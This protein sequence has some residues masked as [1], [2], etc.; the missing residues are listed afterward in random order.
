MYSQSVIEELRVK[1]NLPVNASILN[2]FR[3]P[4]RTTPKYRETDD[5]ATI[6]LLNDRGWFIKTYKQVKPHTKYAD[7]GIYKPFVAMYEN[8]NLPAMEGEGNITLVHRNAKDGTKLNELFAG[9]YRYVCENGLILGNALF[10]P[11]R[12][13]HIG[14]M[15][16]QLDT[17]VVKICDA[18]PLVY[19]A[20]TDMQSVVLT[21]DQQFE[22]ATK[23]IETRF[24]GEKYV[25]DPA[26]VL[27]P[28]RK[29]DEG[30][31]L[32]RVFNRCQENLIKASGLQMK[33]KDNKVRKVK[34]ITNIDVNL[35][36]NRA[37]WN[38]SQSY[39]V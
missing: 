5:I 30:N 33:N 23:A 12:V 37:L 28:N 17:V 25:V 24:D 4:D 3:D 26:L 29:E 6:Q 14:D 9:F 36:V 7:K 16:Q 39:L 19:K 35:K 2:N 18:C 32:W 10:E 34:A 21:R 20:I 15:P 27:A 8:K 1:N 38:L 11:V 31:D 13:K 22:F